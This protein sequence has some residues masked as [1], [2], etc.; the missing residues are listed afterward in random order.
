MVINFLVFGI[1]FSA[2][3]YGLLWLNR[4]YYERR[5]ISGR[6][7]AFAT[8]TLIAGLIA[9]TLDGFYFALL[10]TS[11]KGATLAELFNCD[12]QLNRDWLERALCS[13]VAAAGP[14]G[15]VTLIVTTML[16]KGNIKPQVLGCGKHFP[17]ELFLNPRRHH[18]P[19]L[20]STI[21]AALIIS[22]WSVALTWYIPT[23]LEWIK[24]SAT[25]I[26]RL[27]T[28]AIPIATR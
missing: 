15:T 17:G 16:S 7:Y 27:G 1:F 9:P 11:G 10:L 4:A 8:A 23:G 22:G 13:I 18:R 26:A 6:F 25:E 12:L 20:E 21:I 24:D 5:T 2:G 3:A 14:I 28:G 19:A